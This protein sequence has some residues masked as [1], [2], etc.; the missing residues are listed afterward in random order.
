MA[1]AVEVKKQVPPEVIVYIPL[2]Y[3][4]APEALIVTSAPL[5]AIAESG[6]DI[7]A[8]QSIFPFEPKL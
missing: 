5:E 4:H 8:Y 3:V 1:G 2:L 7:P 6:T